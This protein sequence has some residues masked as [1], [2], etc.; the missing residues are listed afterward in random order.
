MRDGST[1]L[2]TGGTSGIGHEAVRALR[3]QG[4]RVFVGARSPDQ[5]R[6]ALDLPESDVHALDLASLS[7]V[8]AFAEACPP[9]DGL[10]A[11]AGVQVV[12]G[13]RYTE[14]G[15]EMTFAVNHLA[16][17]LLLA[18]VLPRLSPGARVVFTISG[19]HNPEE[20]LA[21]LFGFRGGLYTDFD[22]LL[23]GD[24]GVVASS[25]MLG[26]HRYATSK[27]V[28]VMSVFELARRVPPSRACFL[29]YDPGLVP[30][31]GLIRDQPRV[32]QRAY[33]MLTPL[34]EHLPGATTPQKSGASL[35]WVATSPELR[36]QT[37]THFDHHRGPARI[38]N[39]ADD[40]QRCRDL[41]DGSARSTGASIPT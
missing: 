36:G 20:R 22:R 4:H 32:M 6:R 24:V 18:L 10:V 1:L 7:S 8:R 35:A 34:L 12:R 16:H 5:A 30:A 21:R 14:D 39:R 23:R 31:T 26:M 17:Y 27:L 37:G 19:T 9:A 3:E 40:A 29:G 33:G 38:W 13:T 15:Y 28:N 41:F 11:N 25:R 2:V